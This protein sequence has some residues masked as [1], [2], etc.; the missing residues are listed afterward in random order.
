M[1]LVR[2]KIE[3][4][5]PRKRPANTAQREKATASFFQQVL[6]GLVRNVDF[7]GMRMRLFFSKPAIFQTGLTTIFAIA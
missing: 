6:D 5:I 1:T 7:G 2:A 3:V 4:S